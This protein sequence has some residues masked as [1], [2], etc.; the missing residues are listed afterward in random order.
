MAQR[1]LFLCPD[2][3]TASGGIAV[4][5]DTVVVLRAAGY[6][7]AIVH[8]SPGAGYPDYP[9]AP[10]MYYTQAVLLGAERFGGRKL[11]ATG[12][13][14]RAR[15]RVRGGRLPRVELREDDVI[16]TPEFM[17]ADALA[18]FPHNE[19]GVF[20]QNPFT[21]NWAFMLAQ[22]RG[23]KPFD[24]VGWY[25]GIADICMHQF[26]LL[27]LPRTFYMPVSMKPEEFPFAQDKAPLI[28][29]MPRKRPDEAKM[30]DLALRQ[31][32]GIAGYRL[33]AI[34]GMP[35]TAVSAKLQESRIFISLLKQE[36]LGF[37]AAEAMASGCI[38]VGFTGLGTEEYFTPETGVPVPEGDLYALVRAVEVVVAEYEQDPTRLD[39]LRRHA[40]EAVN[41]RYNRKAFESALLDIWRDLE[42]PKLRKQA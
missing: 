22:T 1:Y 25:I 9:D 5:Y 36:A 34:D 35:R 18:A 20:V 40:S 15:D 16:V 12:P 7:A 39:A 30:I 37:P 11:R 24:R 33:E 10:P 4:I 14:L 41:A 27:Q 13:L 31:R 19:I 17:L 38:T 42:G 26:E 3:K 32:S 6:E 23:F 8:N 21:F 29:Y 2:R 28:T